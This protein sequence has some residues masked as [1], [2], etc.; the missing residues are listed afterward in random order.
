MKASPSDSPE[1][2]QNQLLAALPEA[3]WER[4]SRHLEP[5]DLPL[6]QVLCESGSTHDY[7]YFPTTAIVSLVYLTQDGAS[8]EVAVVGNDGVVGISLFMGGNAT[9]NQAMVQSAGRGYR[10]RAQVV[11]EEALRPGPAFD[12]LLRY[13]LAMLMQVAQTAACNRHHSVDQLL[14]RRLLMGLDRSSTD[15]MVMTQEL[16]ASLLGV[17]REGV[18]AAARR[19]QL[20]GVIHYRRGRIAVLDRGRLERCASDQSP[21]PARWPDERSVRWH[22][23]TSAA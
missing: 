14:C 16:A 10:M 19:L 6:G 3:E 11:K 22:T 23:V 15:D 20:A 2:L 5:V 7:A 17:R 12:V 8:A 21:A 1:P 9:L 18:T 4:W 13:A